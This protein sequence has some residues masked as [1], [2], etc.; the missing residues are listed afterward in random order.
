MRQAEYG[1]P[2]STG[3]S[4]HREPA[5]AGLLAAV[6]WLRLPNDDTRTAGRSTTKDS[7]SRSW[8]HLAI[9]IGLDSSSRRQLPRTYEC[10]KCHQPIGSRCSTATMSPIAPSARAAFMVVVYAE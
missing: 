1:Q 5:P 3:Q 8:Q 9:S 7:Q 4:R 10:A 2:G 6:K